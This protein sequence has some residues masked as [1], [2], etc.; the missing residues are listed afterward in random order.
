MEKEK[1]N[2]ESEINFQ[3]ILLQILEDNRRRDEDNRRRD[4]NFILLVQSLQQ[5]HQV[6]NSTAERLMQSL[7]SRII[8]FLYA[9]DDDHTFENW[10]RR[11]SD[12]FEIDVLQLTDDAKARLLVSKLGPTEFKRFADYILH[13]N[14]MK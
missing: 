3:K 14:L 12:L 5:S 4:E 1:G 10:N 2:S 11:Y 13:R 6:N 8:E 7:T 9:P